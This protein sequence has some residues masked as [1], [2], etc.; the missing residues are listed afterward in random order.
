MV[1][2]VERYPHL[3][4]RAGEQKTF[5]FRIFAHDVDR[6]TGV[7][8]GD[9][10]LPTLAAVVRAPDVR[11]EIV[12]AQRIHGGV[13]RERIGMSRVHDRDLAP[14]LRTDLRRRDIAPVRT[15]VGRRVD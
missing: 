5:L 11:P 9:D 1:T 3:A 4:L 8:A 7:D 10:L 13:R 6:G 12:D 15:A 14:R 2:V